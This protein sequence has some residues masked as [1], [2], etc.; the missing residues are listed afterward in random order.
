MTKFK[1]VGI[2]QWKKYVK[3]KEEKL[4]EK[5]SLEVEKLDKDIRRSTVGGSMDA[6]M[7]ECK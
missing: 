2:G 1:S 4:C 7:P 5:I 6:L 3:D